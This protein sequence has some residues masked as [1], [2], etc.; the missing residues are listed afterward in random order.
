MR[1]F[2]CLLFQKTVTFVLETKKT[3][4][5]TELIELQRQVKQLLTEFED[6][7]QV[8]IEQIQLVKAQK[9]PMKFNDN[10][11]EIVRAE[12]SIKV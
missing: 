6:K 4:M 12:I 5:K 3:Q 9:Y 7:H 1:L 10:F 2:L 8:Q 11:L